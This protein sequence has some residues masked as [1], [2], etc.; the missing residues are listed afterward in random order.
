MHASNYGKC[1]EDLNFILTT[2]NTIR[3]LHIIDYQQATTIHSMRSIISTALVA[4]QGAL[5]FCWDMLLNVPL[6]TGWQTI[7]HNKEALVNKLKASQ[8]GINYDYY[9]GKHFLKYDQTIKE[10]LT[11]KTFSPFEVVHVH[12]NGLI[13]I[14]LW[15]SGMEQINI[16][17]TI[18]Y[19]DSLV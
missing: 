16:C 3:R 11:I 8:Q 17:Y 2:S 1:V 4:S 9:V 18:P 6:I 5:A 12:V 19:K 14:Q 15:P 10:K 13:T 7:S